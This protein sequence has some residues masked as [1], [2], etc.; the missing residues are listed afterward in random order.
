MFMIIIKNSLN[1]LLHIIYYFSIKS[2][3]FSKSYNIFL[4]WNIKQDL[5]RDI[6]NII[7]KE[8]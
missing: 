4:E 5:I 7:C 1:I 8:N 2:L 3:L 6:N